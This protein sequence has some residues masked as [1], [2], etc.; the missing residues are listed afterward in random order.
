MG[1]FDRP[2]LVSTPS[3]DFNMHKCS[4]DCACSSSN[5]GKGY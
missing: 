1:V 4:F 2:R 5:K 3:T